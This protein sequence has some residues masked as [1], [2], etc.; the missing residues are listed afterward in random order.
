MLCSWGI[1]G[2]LHYIIF[3]IYSSQFGCISTTVML[4]E[5]VDF[6]WNHVMSLVNQMIN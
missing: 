6:I 4:N 3:L 5:A 1:V 2:A